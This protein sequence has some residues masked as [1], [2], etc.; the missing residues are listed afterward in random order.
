[1]EKKVIRCLFVGYDGQRKGWRC[2]DPTTKKFYTSQD[3]VFDEASSWWSSNNDVLPDTEVFKE[4]LD[5]SHVQ[6]T[7]KDDGASD[8]DQNAQVG[9][10]QNPWH[11]GVYQRHEEG[12]SNQPQVEDALRR[13]TRPRKPNPRYANAAIVEADQKEPETFEEAFQNV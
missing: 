9:A 3:A 1:M 5:D 11:T 12:D 7:L 8:S 13:S 4:A 6:L 10:G 2:F